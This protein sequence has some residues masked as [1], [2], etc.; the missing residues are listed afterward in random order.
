MYE[1]LLEL[2][3]EKYKGTDK[4]ILAPELETDRKDVMPV[5]LSRA[6]SHYYDQLNTGKHLKYKSLRKTYITNLSIYMSGNAKAITGHSDDAVI[7]RHY[8]DKIVIAKAAQGYEVW[9]VQNREQELQNVRD[10][11]NSK[12]K[13]KEVTR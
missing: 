3:Y 7:E 5:T 13:N 4:Y 2:G 11:S 6:F 8:L 9:A 10:E 1:L 12:A